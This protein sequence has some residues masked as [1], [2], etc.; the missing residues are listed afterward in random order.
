MVKQY[1][2]RSQILGNRSLPSFYR[3]PKKSCSIYTENTLLGQNINS[4]NMVNNIWGY[5]SLAI[6]V[7]P[8]S[9]EIVSIFYSV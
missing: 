8:Y 4:K 9:F 5:T 6:E 7:Y 2:S 3:M 1:F